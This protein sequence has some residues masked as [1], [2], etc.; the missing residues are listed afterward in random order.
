[1]LLIILAS[2]L[3]FLSVLFVTP[4]IWCMLGRLFRIENLTYM[5]A[6]LT[7]VLIF[8]LGI[9]LQILIPLV[10]VLLKI[11]SGF[12]DFLL[13]IT[14]LVVSIAILKIRFGTTVWKSIGL[15]LS[16][17]VFSVILTLTYRTYV[18]QA[19]KIPSGAMNNTILVGDHILV[20]KFYYRF[21]PPSHGDI[22]V[23][24][25][26]KDSSKDYIK[27]IVAVGGDTV[28]IRDK[29]VYI[30]G[31]A[32]MGHFAI[33]S[34]PLIYSDPEGLNKNYVRRDNLPQIK[35]PSRKLFVL[36]DNRDASNDS[37]FWG[38]V[39]ES[40]VRGRAFFIYWSWD[41]NT[42]SVRW[43]RIWEPL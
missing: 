28:E 43:E 15:H 13:S 38:M 11:Y 26:P 35:I 41:K 29:I 24:K 30:N 37:R 19:Y 23:F 40:D 34:D 39:D 21:H 22:I 10:L 2:I 16:T 4:F 9:F 7:C 3:I 32:E 20:N 8:L 14:T 12:F 36:G 5:K 18:V 1:M 33:Y 25:F 27:R 6:L 17:L 31:A 42:A